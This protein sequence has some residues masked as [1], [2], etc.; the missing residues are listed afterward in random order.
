MIN[1]NKR[2]IKYLVVNN[3]CSE[4]TDS[5]IESGLLTMRR[6]KFSA[7]I[8]RLSTCKAGGKGKEVLK[9]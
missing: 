8:A 4:A 6:G 7:L 3:L 9:R 2:V 1:Y 5:R